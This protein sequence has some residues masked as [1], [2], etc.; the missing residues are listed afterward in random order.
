MCIHFQH[1]HWMDDLIIEEE[2]PMTKCPNCLLFCRN[3]Y[4]QQHINSNLCRDGAIRHQKRLQQLHSENAEISTLTIN[5]T[6]LEHVQTFKYL[7][8]PLS[9]TSTDQVAI[10]YNLQKAT[11]SWG[12]ISNIL[13]RE[14]ADPN[15]MGNFYRAV[16]QSV[17][18]YGSET[19]HTSPQ[20]ITKLESFHHKIARH[21]THRHIRKM[22]NSD[23]WVYPNMD[24]VLQAAG[25]L[26]LQEY[27]QKRK[28]TLLRWAQNRD[29]YHTARQLEHTLVGNKKFWGVDVPD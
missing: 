11:K 24:L 5:N 25:L 15:T 16:V 10:N 20:N 13:R 12:R 3:P 6:E 29:I 9:A 14:G 18:L 2:E 22:A 8:R 1:R 17:L 19:W 28:T 4:T 23:I 7:G 21:I 27:I 26:P